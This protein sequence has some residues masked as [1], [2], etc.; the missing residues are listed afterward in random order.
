[1]TRLFANANY[2][3]IG[4]RK[5]AYIVTAIIMVPGL[6][7]LAVSGFNYSIEFTGGTQVQVHALKPEMNIGA[8]RTALDQHGL[9]G[10]EISEYG[11]V[12]DFVIR[13]RLEGAGEVNE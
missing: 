1:M 2:D 12:H 13:T 11:S 8:V 6:V 10:A 9:R 5:I 7:M 3:F 4:L